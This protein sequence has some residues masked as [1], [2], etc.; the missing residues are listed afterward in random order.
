MTVTY[1]T[2]LPAE[3]RL[4]KR[5]V[6]FERIIFSDIFTL[7]KKKAIAMLQTPIF[8]KHTVYQLCPFLPGY[9]T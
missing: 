1:Y 3:V 6:P 5:L 4:D 8:P 9:Q 7:A 2:I